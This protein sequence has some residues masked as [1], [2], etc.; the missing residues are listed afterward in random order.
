[1]T[2]LDQPGVI[3]DVAAIFRD[4]EI[5]IESMLQHGRA[6]AEAVPVVL[7]THDTAEA[8]MTAALRRIG[9]LSSVKAPPKMIRIEM[10]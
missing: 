10:L 3:A 1:L 2:V 8:A 6:P 4:N 5:S 9:K 7:I